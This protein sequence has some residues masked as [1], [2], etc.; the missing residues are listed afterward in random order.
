[1]PRISTSVDRG[2]T[3]RQYSHAREPIM[4][5]ST[6]RALPR[7]R[8]I[9]LTTGRRPGLGHLHPWY[10]ERDHTDISDYS[11]TA[12]AELKRAAAA[13]LGPDNPVNRPK[14]PEDDHI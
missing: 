10:R 2:R 13:T 8:A 1:V 9:L 7:D 6:L 14:E 4:P 11:H 12:L 5:P 3:S